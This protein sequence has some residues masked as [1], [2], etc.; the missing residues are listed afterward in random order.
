MSELQKRP[1]KS[2]ISRAVKRC[3]ARLDCGDRRGLQCGKVADEGVL[4]WV[5][6]RALENPE[7]L[8][9]LKHVHPEELKPFLRR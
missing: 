4:C 5:H 3:H 1:K 2:P 8:V 7:R 6:A 9:P